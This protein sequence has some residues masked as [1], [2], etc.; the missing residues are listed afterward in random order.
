VL[1]VTLAAIV[2]TQNLLP[3]REP[4]LRLTAGHRYL[5]E[6]VLARALPPGSEQALDALLLGLDRALAAALLLLLLG[7]G[8]RRCGLGRA[9]AAKGLLVSLGA[10]LLTLLLCLP[11]A[12][13]LS[14]E[15]PWWGGMRRPLLGVAGLWL[16]AFGLELLLRGVLQAV[17]IA[18]L[19]RLLGPRRRVLAVVLG[20][21]L[22]ALWGTLL[23]AAPLAAEGVTGW[24]LAGR[25]AHQGL[26]LGMV[27]GG[28]FA[29]TGN[30]VL[31]GGLHGSFALLTRLRLPGWPSTFASSLLL[32]VALLLVTA[33]LSRGLLEP[34]GPDED[35]S[36]D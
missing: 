11:L 4:L 1:L 3:P 19:S 32:L 16:S 13:L 28:I 22:A 29:R 26:L 20:V 14:P 10:L 12:H 23:L 25:L 35:G 8:A 21:L 9:A 34:A 27:L 18:G 17:A 33:L 7:W 5:T 15:A 6:P 30:L 24:D 31:V 36:A 2:G